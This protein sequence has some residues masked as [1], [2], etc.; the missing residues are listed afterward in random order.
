MNEIDVYF[1]DL[2]FEK[3]TKKILCFLFLCYCNSFCVSL[4]VGISLESD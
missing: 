1:N 2:S 3:I 4:L